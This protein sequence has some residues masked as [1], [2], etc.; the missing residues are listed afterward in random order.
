MG[1]SE[2]WHLP[3]LQFASRL[4]GS[5]HRPFRSKWSCDWSRNSWCYHLGES[6]WNKWFKFWIEFQWKV[7]RLFE[8]RPFAYRISAGRWGV[9]VFRRPVKWGNGR[10]FWKTDP[11]PPPRSSESGCWNRF[12]SFDPISFFFNKLKILKLK[13][14][15]RIKYFNWFGDWRH[16]FLVERRIIFITEFDQPLEHFSPK[17]VSWQLWLKKIL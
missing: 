6:P 12:S 5:F 1:L 15:I 9:R 3:H 10:W 2:G 16:H 4:R 13:V 14:Q 8:W 11:F 7:F 17:C